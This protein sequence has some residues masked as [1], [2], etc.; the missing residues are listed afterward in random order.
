MSCDFH[1]H[2]T[3]AGCR[4]KELEV[5]IKHTSIYQGLTSSATVLINV[6][7]F[8]SRPH[9]ST[10]FSSLCLL[11]PSAPSVGQCSAGRGWGSPLVRMFTQRR[12]CG[13]QAQ[14]PETSRTTRNETKPNSLHTPPSSPMC[15]LK[16]PCLLKLI[17]TNKCNAQIEHTCSL[18]LSISAFFAH[19]YTVHAPHDNNSIGFMHS[20]M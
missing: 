13:T 10:C 19:T 18:P 1:E 17:P 3:A 11:P 8:F 12:V 15:I 16:L 20:C 14:G 6:G 7:L 2:F 5:K 4:S 9:I